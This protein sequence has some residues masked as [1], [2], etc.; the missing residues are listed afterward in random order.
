VS[1]D[2]QSPSGGCREF[3]LLIM[4][5]LDGEISP[6]ENERLEKHLS[7]CP[8]C[9]KALSDYSRLTDVTSEVEMKKVGD[10][11]WDLYWCRVYNRL[12]RG[13]AW[14]LVCI[15]AAAVLAYAL[16]RLVTEL[17]ADPGMA[18]WAKAGIIVLVVG[19]ALLFVSVL[20]EQLTI[21]CSDKYRGIKR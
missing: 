5:R 13:V 7:T 10:E 14:I 3:E 1:D 9:R 6:E 2:T 19:L 4:R 11:E 18:A 17:I 20:R 16:F 21:R 8:A 15:G 12:E